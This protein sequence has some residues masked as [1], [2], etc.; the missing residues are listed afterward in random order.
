MEVFTN[1]IFLLAGFFMLIKGADYL[2]DGAS[3][4]AKRFG[5][6]TLVIGLTVVA[7]GTSAPEIV[8][9]LVAAIG[10]NPEIALGN[11]N[12][13]VIANTLLILGI[14]AF[15]S[16]IPVKSR[17][18]VKEIPFMILA[19][20]VLLI[21]TLDQFINGDAQAVLS[22][23]DGIIMILI[24]GVFL[25][26]LFLSVKGSPFA[27]EK[28]K[29][30]VPKAIGLTLFGLL[31]LM[32]GAHLTVD[33]ASGL[34]I[35]AGV[36]ES[37]VAL[38]VVAL[39]TSLP[40]L[41]AAIMA[42]RKG[43]MDLAVGSVV[44]SNIFDILL[45]LGL[46]AVIAPM[47]ISNSTIIDVAIVLASLT[48]LLIALFITRRNADDGEHRVLDRREGIILLSLYVLYIVY[49]VIRG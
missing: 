39:G 34:A 5:I 15:I 16:K 2:I 49:V 20:L 45:G 28:T 41:T 21:F 8:V 9:N 13:T 26:Y 42:A 38:T 4:I 43:E 48:I 32:L 25:Y 24:F 31:G 27:K 44:G 17:T 29:M 14:G 1:I 33:G 47:V 35:A 40:E 19:A 30:R 23:I 36:S 7:F 46:S 18:V 3:S 10:G 11:I 22:R 6:P 12:G 37:L